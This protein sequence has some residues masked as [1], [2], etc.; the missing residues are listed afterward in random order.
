[1]HIAND[2]LQILNGCIY[3]LTHKRD[4]LLSYFIVL[5]RSV[6]HI[7]LLQNIDLTEFSP[8][9]IRNFCIIAHVDHGKSTLA[10][11]MLEI[12]GKIHHKCLHECFTSLCNDSVFIQVFCVNCLF[13]FKYFL[14]QQVPF[15]IQM[16]I[17]IYT[18]ILEMKGRL[19]CCEKTSSK[20]FSIFFLIE[21]QI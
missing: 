9:R 16:Y 21:L 19:F 6:Y 1:M 14:D 2:V 4:P 13:F 20:T 10:D 17:C 8:E 15:N 5:Q 11:R 12:T 3:S 18:F 7:L